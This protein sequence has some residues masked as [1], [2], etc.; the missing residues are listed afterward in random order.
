M[1]NKEDI[2]ELFH[3]I[4]GEMLTWL[5]KIGMLAMLILL[6]VVGERATGGEI[7]SAIRHLLLILGGATG[8]SSLVLG[9]IISAD[10]GALDW[11]L[12]IAPVIGVVLIGVAV[13]LLLPQLNPEAITFPGALCVILIILSELCYTVP[14][15][16]ADGRF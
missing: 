13:F 1:M 14:L 4:F 6:V 16:D 9:A 5:T 15:A 11:P 7:P 3:D 10:E 2:K 8:A 12:L